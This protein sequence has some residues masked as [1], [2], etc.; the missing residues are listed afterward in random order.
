MPRRR[1]ISPV[2]EMNINGKL[3]DERTGATSSR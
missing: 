2:S 1:P 3:W